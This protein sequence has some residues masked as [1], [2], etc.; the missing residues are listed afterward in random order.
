MIVIYGYLL[1]TSSV[2]CF[3][4][5]C[6]ALTVWFQVYC[7]FALCGLVGYTL[8]PWSVYLGLCLGFS[9]FVVV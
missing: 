8:L 2:R 7:K 9:C 6:F 1:F 5:G 3:D 4:L